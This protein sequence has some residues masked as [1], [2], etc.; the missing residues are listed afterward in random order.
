MTFHHKNIRLPA[1][2]YRGGEL[3]FVT[4][5]CENR[6]HVFQEGVYCSWF[7]DSLRTAAVEHSFAIYAYCLM[8]DHVH[9]LT[10]G[11]NLKSDFLRFLKALKQTT[12]FEYKRKT[13]RQL[14]QKKSYDRILRSSDSPDP[15]AWY[16]WMNPVRAG[17]CQNAQEYAW[18]GSFTGS[19]PR[20]MQ[21][22]ESWTP[23]WKSK[24]A[25][26]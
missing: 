26:T 12:A 13:G 5:C 21:P 19:G 23:P 1:D 7:L 3:F 4:F 8:P 15:V 10:Q 2:R 9:L 6:E 18:S 22:C 20:R 11:L 25:P 17:I 14:W 24:K 16:I